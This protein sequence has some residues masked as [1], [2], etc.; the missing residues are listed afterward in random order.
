MVVY[1]RPLPVL[2][3]KP[4]SASQKK[5]VEKDLPRFQEEVLRALSVVEAASA[6]KYTGELPPTL[7]TKVRRNAALMGETIAAWELTLSEGWRG[8]FKDVAGPA[9]DRSAALNAEVAEVLA[10][11]ELELPS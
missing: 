1:A 5:K 3:G 7:W 8:D 11:I 4:L 9:N 10:L 2:P 6:E